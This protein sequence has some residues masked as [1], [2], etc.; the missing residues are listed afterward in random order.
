[1]FFPLHPVSPT[2]TLA[3]GTITLIIGLTYKNSVYAFKRKKTHLLNIAIYVIRISR[4]CQNC[5]YCT[6]QAIQRNV[7]IILLRQDFPL[8]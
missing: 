8:M 6:S 5:V 3:R 2:G 4:L 7:R 1:M